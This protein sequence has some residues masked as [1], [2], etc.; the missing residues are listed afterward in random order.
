MVCQW[1][2]SYDSYYSIHIVTHTLTQN[3]NRFP[4]H[5]MRVKFIRTIWI[6]FYLRFFSLS[7]AFKWQNTATSYTQNRAKTQFQNK[8]LYL[9]MQIISFQ[10]AGCCE[11]YASTANML[12]SHILSTPQMETFCIR[13]IHS[14]FVS[15]SRLG[16]RTRETVEL[17]TFASFS[18]L[19]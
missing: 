11:L 7:R 3:L 8:L 5:S 9:L 18:R 10:N 17:K 13:E 12:E 16:E 1:Q 6:S 2:T 4:C 19:Q 14:V 15:W